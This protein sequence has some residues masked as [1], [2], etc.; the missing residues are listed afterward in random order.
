MSHHDPDRTVPDPPGLVLKRNQKVGTLNPEACHGKRNCSMLLR[1]EHY[2]P[3][4]SKLLLS[5]FH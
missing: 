1:K 2:L 4:S 3:S 5:E